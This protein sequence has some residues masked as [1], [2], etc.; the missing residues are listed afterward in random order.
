VGHLSSARWF[1]P[2]RKAYNLLRRSVLRHVRVSAPQPLTFRPRVLV[3]GI[4]LANRRHTADHLARRFGESRQCEVDQK[5]VALNGSPSDPF[6]GRH[7]VM[8]LAGFVPKFVIMNRLLAQTP[9][10]DYDFIVFSDDDVYLPSGFLDAYLAQQVEFGLALAQP[11]RTRNSWADR[12]FCRQMKGIRGRVTRY[13]EI[14]PVFSVTREF[15]PA[16]LP[17]DETSPMGWGYDYVWPL[18]AEAAG[19]R[20][21]IVDATPVDHSIRD[22]AAAYDKYG[23]GAAMAAY[24]A[25]H[26]H[27][28]KPEAFTVLT[29]F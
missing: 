25:K 23:A 4:Y 24:L 7:T 20:I 8:Q 1:R 13:V 9:W 2:V 11:A 29:T 28:S 21:G 15:A 17:F 27:L 18:L 10:Q 26:R 14:G 6:L 3:L 12:K 22:Q 16:I 5:W 19:R